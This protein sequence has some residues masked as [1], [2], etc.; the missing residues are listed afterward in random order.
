MKSF[1]YVV[2]SLLISFSAQ[3]DMIESLRLLPVQDG[4]RLKPLDTF[5]RE[6]LQLVYGKQKFK[7]EGGQGNA[8][9]AT[10]IVMTWVLQPS[11]W[12]GTPIFEINYGE[13]KK[14]LKLPDDRK[15]FSFTEIM[16]NERL[17]TLMQ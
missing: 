11:A 4:G 17:P 6:A 14:S 1:I 13:L 3:A 7:M 8:R 10:E 2:L 9:P 12:Q 15:Y 16:S 5:A